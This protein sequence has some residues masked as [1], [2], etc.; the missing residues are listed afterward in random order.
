M[1]GERGAAAAIKSASFNT[2]ANNHHL[3]VEVLQLCHL[4][5]FLQQVLKS[6][7]RS[8]GNIVDHISSQLADTKLLACKG[9]NVFKICF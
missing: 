3:E 8:M 1:Q 5:H 6:L 7:L 9:S 2:A 4:C